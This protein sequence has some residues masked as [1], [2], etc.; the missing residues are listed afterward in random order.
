MT[1]VY[2]AN[3]DPYLANAPC[4]QLSKKSASHDAIANSPHL[5][6]FRRLL[7][8]YPEGALHAPAIETL[9]PSTSCPSIFA[10]KLAGYSVVFA[11]GWHGTLRVSSVLR[12][13]VFWRFRHPWFSNG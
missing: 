8:S 10:L 11:L 4:A 2:S 9:K 5:E 3:E 12:E 13:A 1:I 6:L 7:F